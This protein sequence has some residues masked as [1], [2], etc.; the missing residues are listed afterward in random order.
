MYSTRKQLWKFML[1][2]SSNSSQRVLCLQSEWRW[3][4]THTHTHQFNNKLYVSCH[5]APYAFLRQAKPNWTQPNRA[6]P[7]KR[8]GILDMCTLKYEMN[9]WLVSMNE[10][11]SIST[12]KIIYYVN[13]I[14][15]EHDINFYAIR[16]ASI[17]NE[18]KKMW[19]IDVVQCMWYR[20]VS[21]LHLIGEFF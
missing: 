9:Y 5:F 19:K 6:E 15:I 16:Q 14:N 3:R 10:H 18:P 13:M 1:L 4:H 2:R 11:D 7:K 8:T 21:S 12:I 17:Q 20:N